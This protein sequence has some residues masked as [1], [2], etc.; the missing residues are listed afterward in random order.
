MQRKCNPLAKNVQSVE[1][2]RKRETEGDREDGRWER[3]K[4]CCHP[5]DFPRLTAAC[6]RLNIKQRHM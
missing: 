4:W 1:F 2:T 5:T 3:E 6:P